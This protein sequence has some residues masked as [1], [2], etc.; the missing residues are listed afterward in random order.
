MLSI[1]STYRSLI[2][3]CS[4]ANYLR[5]CH[6]SAQVLSYS[7]IYK[8]LPDSDKLKIKTISIRSCYINSSERLHRHVL[9]LLANNIEYIDRGHTQACST[10]VLLLAGWNSDPHS[11][12]DFLGSNTHESTPPKRHLDWFIRFCRADS[13]DRHGHTQTQGY[14]IIPRRA[15]KKIE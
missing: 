2:A 8:T 15:D 11:I 3:P 13:L 10:K 5:T 7:A 6:R 4:L 9:L 14:S 12:H 1:S